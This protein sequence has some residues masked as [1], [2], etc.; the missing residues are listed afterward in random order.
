MVTYLA[1]LARWT[2]FALLRLLQP[3]L[4]PILSGLAL[5]GVGLWVIF[6][7]IAGDREFPS[8]RVL[9]MSVVCGLAVLIYSVILEWLAPVRRSRRPF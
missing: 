4:I 7:W 2:G 5:G 1:S 8:L 9:T 6:V 3:I